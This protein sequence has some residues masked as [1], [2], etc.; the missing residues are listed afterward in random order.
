[1]LKQLT[2]R[3]RDTAGVDPSGLSTTSAKPEDQRRL[4][5]AL[6]AILDAISAL[7]PPEAGALM[8]YLFT[9]AK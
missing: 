7:P 2:L 9:A 3:I 6:A 5:L 8:R 1:V 4:C